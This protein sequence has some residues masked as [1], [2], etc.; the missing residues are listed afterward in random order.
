VRSKGQGRNV[1]ENSRAAPCHCEGASATEQSCRSFLAALERKGG[2]RARTGI[3]ARKDRGSLARKPCSPCHCEGAPAT[4][5][6]CEAFSLR[7]KGQGY[8]RRTGGCAQGQ[9]VRLRESRAALVIARERQRL[10]NLVKLSRCARKDKEGTLARTGGCA[11][12]QG[13]R[14]REQPCSPC[15]CEGASATEKACEDFSLR[16]KGQGYARRTGGCAQGQGVR[17]RESRAAPCHCE[18]ASAT[19]K[20]CRRFLATLEMTGGCARKDRGVRS[21]GQG[22][23]AQGQRV[24]LERTGSCARKDRGVRA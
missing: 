6:S 3:C 24:A 23:C 4:E 18:G 12:G 19:E 21:K 8:A 14:L 13:V 1:C 7:S 5:Q 22:V 10:S 16:S 11:Q 20:A 17:L 2:V 15:H 9:G